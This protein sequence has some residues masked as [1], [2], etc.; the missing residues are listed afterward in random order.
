[1]AR[2]CLVGAGVISRVHAEALRGRVS[3]PWSIPTPP[4]R[5]GWPSLRRRDPRLSGRRAR[6]RRVRS[7]ARAGAAAAARRRA[8]A[9]L[10]AGIPVLLEKPMAATRRRMPGAAGRRARAAARC[11]ASTRTSSS[12]RLSRGCAR[13][14][15]PALRA[16]ALSV[17][18][19]V[20]LRQL[21]ARQFGHWMFA[22]RA[23]CCSNRRC[24]RSRRF[25]R[26]PAPVGEL[27]V[28]PAGRS[29]SRPACRS[30]APRRARCR[31]KT[32][33]AAALRG[34]R[35]FPFWQVTAVCDDGVLVA[36]ILANRA[37]PDGRTRWLEPVDALSPALRTAGGLAR[38]SLATPPNTRSPR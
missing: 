31:R 19:H 37:R 35:A 21:A 36:D 34:R 20:P 5:S 3:R 2:V 30:S 22:R 28:L 11:S 32:A 14:S 24:I 25:S 10:A 13:W 15:T 12:T 8:A 4:P 27:R 16:A 38:D 1:M 9:L 33:G 18:L 26:S 6:G 23:T 29:R 7:R 17:H